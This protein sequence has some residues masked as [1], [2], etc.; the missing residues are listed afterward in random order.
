MKNEVHR[1]KK[2]VIAPLYN[3]CYEMMSGTL[4][5]SS[6]ADLVLETAYI[7][8]ISIK[9]F[10]KLSNDRFFLAGSHFPLFNFLVSQTT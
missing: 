1:P 4:F 10:V 8:A 2:L 3:K 9:G 7:H 5:K 6:P